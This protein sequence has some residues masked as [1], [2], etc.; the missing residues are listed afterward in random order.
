LKHKE[1]LRKLWQQT[2]DPACKTAINWVTK[3]IRRLTS[4]TAL[5]E[6]VTKIGNTRVTTQVIRPIE[7]SLL[8]RDEAR[9]PNNILG[10]SG[11]KFHPSEKANAT[12]DYLDIN[13][14]QHDLCE[15]TVKGRFRLQ[16]KLLEAGRTSSLSE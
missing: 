4:K 7:K 16:F 9:A 3:S 14:A 10:P 15:K 12:A 1:R 2:C 8:K 13:F 5:E 6:W 11:L